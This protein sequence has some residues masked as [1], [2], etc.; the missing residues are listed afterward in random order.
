[1]KMFN[2]YGGD[3]VIDVRD[4]IERFEHLEQLR[5][6]GPVDL[7]DDDNE[8]DQDDLFAELA[9]LETFLSDLR[10]NGEDEQWRGGWYPVTLIRDSYFEDYARELAEDIGAIRSDVGWPCNCIDWKQA[11][12]ELQLD[13][14]TV[15][16]CGV[17]YWCR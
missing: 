17:T 10:G 4:V 7:G 15:K 14:S 8:Q 16:I 12:R 11:A 13:Y 3:D 6:P 5:Q 2:I 1:M 9:D